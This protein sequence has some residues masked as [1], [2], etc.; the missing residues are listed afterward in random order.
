MSEKHEIDIKITQKIISQKISHTQNE[1]IIFNCKNIFVKTHSSSY[2]MGGGGG[3]REAG[4]CFLI[5]TQSCFCKH[6]NRKT[7]KK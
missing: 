5:V 1:K 2:G 7:K 3:R 4:K 6:L